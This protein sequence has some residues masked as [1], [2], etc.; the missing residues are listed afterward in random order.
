LNG[1]IDVE[2]LDRAMS[3]GPAL[4]WAA[5]GPHLSYH[6]GAGAAGVS[7]F[8]QRLLAS[9]EAWWA[10]LATWNQLDG[11]RRRALLDAIQGA[12]GDRVEELRDIRDRRLGD[13][14]RA[15]EHARSL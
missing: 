14:L 9:F 8:L 15:L 1:V 6:L 13:L 12:Y 11:E 10:D 2:D 4:G 3:L 7:I 5:A